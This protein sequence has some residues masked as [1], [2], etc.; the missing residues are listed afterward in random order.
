M[1]GSGLITFC[2]APT[3]QSTYYKDRRTLSTCSKY[4][5]GSSNK[6]DQEERSWNVKRAGQKQ[7]ARARNGCVL[8]QKIST[9]SIWTY[10]L[11]EWKRGCHGLQT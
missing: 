9:I 8:K 3:R 2:S 5:T 6:Y 10:I 1:A 11:C 7:R 4:K